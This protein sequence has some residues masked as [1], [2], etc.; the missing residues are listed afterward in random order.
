MSRPIL[1]AAKMRAAEAR[2]IEAGTTETMLMERAGAALAKAISLYA[3]PRETLLLCGPGNNG[4]DGY[5]AARHLAK[6]D[7]PCASRRWTSPSP[8]PLAGQRA[9]GMARLNSFTSAAEAPIIVDCLFGTGLSRG[10]DKAVFQRLLLLADKALVAVA[11]DL[12]SGVSSDDGALLSP[13]GQY[14]L[15]VT[16][17][18]LEARSPADAGNGQHGPG[19]PGRHWDRGRRGLVRDRR[20]GSAAARSPGPQI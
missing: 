8:R 6:Q 1:T 16:F 20:S 10:L 9:N 17:G 7:I 3:G 12:P 15:T 11:C 19:R 13:I 18:A 5:V 4:G 14:D 2:A